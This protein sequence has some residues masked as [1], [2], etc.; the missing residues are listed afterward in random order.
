MTVATRLLAI[1]S[2]S[3]EPTTVLTLVS[4]KSAPVTIEVALTRM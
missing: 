1:V 3:G 4:T 2:D